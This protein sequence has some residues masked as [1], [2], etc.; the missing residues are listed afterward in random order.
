MALYDRVK[1]LQAEKDAASTL[2]NS[3]DGAFSVLQAVVTREKN[4]LQSSIDVQTASVI[5][6]QSL[7]QSLHSTLDSFK[8]ADKEMFD[9]AASQ[10]QIRAALAIAKAGGPLPE[11]DSIKDALSAVTKDAASQFSS[12]TD[13]LRDLYQT[14]NDVAD[15]AGITDKSLSTEE[16]SLQALKDE[17]TRLD[18]MVSSA[19]ELVNVAKGSSSTL[20][21][22]DQAMAGLS[23]GSTTR[24]VR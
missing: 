4:A 2:M 7:S 8:S 5:K 15:L 17:V 3:V 12:Y 6:L 23:L 9:R 24:N 1:A 19:Q 16:E 11:A 20:L 10:A 18:A 13:Y 22:I 14:Q 21:S